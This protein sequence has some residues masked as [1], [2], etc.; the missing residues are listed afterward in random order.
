MDITSYILGKKAGSGD[1]PTRTINITENGITNVSSY[2]TADVNV[3]PDLESKE[4]TITS[5]TTTDITP[6]TGKD[7]LSQVSV[8][9]NIQPNLETKSITITENTTTTI[10]PTSGKDGLSSV[11]VTTNVS[12][13]DEWSDIGYSS[14]PQSI[15]DAHTYSKQLYDGWD[16]NNPHKFQYDVNLIICPLIDTSEMTNIENMFNGCTSLIQV[17]AIVVSNNITSLQ[18]MFQGCR[19]LRTIDFSNFDVSNIVYTYNMFSDCIRLDDNTLNGILDLCIKMTSVNSKTLSGMGITN[20]SIKNRIPT[21]SNYQAFLDA[22][23]TIS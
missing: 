2:A 9:T 7:G 8:I 22:G 20:T 21:L 12:G 16:A 19:A 4:I 10:T 5:N 15:V 17:P 13:G 11:E 6:T 23:W 14:T 18:Y 1:T 3:R